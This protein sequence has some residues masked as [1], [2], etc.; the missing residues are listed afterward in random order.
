VDDLLEARGRRSTDWRKLCE[1]ASPL[2]SALEVTEEGQR[3]LREEELQPE[4]R[5]LLTL[6][7]GRKTIA[8]VIEQSGSDA[9]DALTVLVR[10]LESGWLSAHERSASLFPMRPQNEPL[11]P[12]PVPL[13]RAKDHAFTPSGISLRKHTVIGLGMPIDEIIQQYR[14]NASEHAA[15]EKSASATP[16]AEPPKPRAEV[17]RIISVGTP[18]AKPVD[19]RRSDPPDG[20]ERRQSSSPPASEGQVAKPISEKDLAA[21]S[22]ASPAVHPTAPGGKYV[23]RYEVLYRIGRGGMGSVYL[24]RLTSEGGFRRL[25]ALKLLRSHLM[26][27][28][29]AAHNFLE[30]ARLAGQI[31]HPNVVSVLDAGLHNSQPYLVMDYIE[32]TSLKQLLSLNGSS[33]PPEVILPIILDALSGLH[34]ANTLVG[35]DGSPLE[36]VHCDVSPEN[37]LVG[38]DG[39]CRLTDFGVAR[40]GT[41]RQREMVTHGK[42]GYLAPEQIQGGNVDRR[43]D[44]FAMGVVLY[45]ALTGTRLFEGRTIQETLRLVCTQHIEPPSTVGVKPPPSL[46]FVCMKALERDPAR[47]FRS[48]EEMMIEL[49]RVALRENMLAPTSEVAAWVRKSVGAELAQRRLALFDASRKTDLKDGA[50]TVALDATSG[51][52]EPTVALPS[53]ADAEEGKPKEAEQ[54]LSRT[55]VLPSIVPDEDAQAVPTAA[56]PSAAEEPAEP[57]TPA[58]ANRALIFA[59]ALAALLVIVTVAWPS[60][61]SK[62]FRLHTES[63]VAKDLRLEFSARPLVSAAPI[64]VPSASP[65]QGPLDALPAAAPPNTGSES[66]ASTDPASP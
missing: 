13:V 34:A 53:D 48:A 66:R 37:L 12:A 64:L 10:D 41:L 52:P 57:E 26:S 44:V 54:P 2:S 32:G 35:D 55:I 40:H 60:F 4:H 8:E 59:A 30:E 46:D 20:R 15:Q 61:V 43:A 27:N 45:N 25:F 36:I 47:R 21:T 42:P 23:G 3:A 33:R 62:L 50:T 65:P 1:T 29:A 9:V 24:C 6:V 16:S 58:W 19:A 63:V 22:E 11:V 28:S 31:H 17:Q 56:A 14:S 39:V 49:R 5:T 18:A 7:D 51:S 38:I